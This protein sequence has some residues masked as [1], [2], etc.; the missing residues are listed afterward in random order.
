M[1]RV[2]YWALLVMATGLVAKADYMLLH[3][4]TVFR[5]LLCKN[6]VEKLPL[7][8]EP[9]REAV[10]VWQ[11]GIQVCKWQMWH[12]DG[13]RQLDA[14]YRSAGAAS[15]F[16]AVAGSFRNAVMRDIEHH[17]ASSKKLL[18][19]K[20]DVVVRPVASLVATSELVPTILV[21]QTTFGWG[22]GTSAPGDQLKL[23]PNCML[24]VEELIYLFQCL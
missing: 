4:L 12:Q 18:H 23:T 10:L 13:L 15:S 6:V 16:Q 20:H 2:L 3:M 11:L 24:H 1:L 8:Q 17:V 5:V 14:P 9:E 7:D 19:K 21:Q 22:A